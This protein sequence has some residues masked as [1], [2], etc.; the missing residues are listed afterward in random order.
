MC[1]ANS[2]FDI[3]RIR[4]LCAPLAGS[5]RLNATAPWLVTSQCRTTMRSLTLNLVRIG[6]GQREAHRRQLPD[7]RNDHDTA[8]TNMRQSST[9]SDVRLLGVPV[10]PKLKAQGTGQ[11]TDGRAAINQSHSRQRTGLM[12][13]DDRKVRHQVQPTGSRVP[14]AVG[15]LLD[16]TQEL[17]PSSM[18]AWASWAAASGAYS[19]V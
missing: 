11:N 16:K 2:L 18:R 10:E 4:T 9:K 7:C 14:V 12:A 17:V 5:S 8:C 3:S 1:N 19:G 15:K 6:P 13:K